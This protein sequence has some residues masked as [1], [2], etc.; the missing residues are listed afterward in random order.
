MATR[1]P[2]QA[3]AWCKKMVGTV[4]YGGYCL[5]FSRTA[6][7]IPGRYA[8]AKLAWA[9]ADK[10]HPTS[11]T[12][13][14]PV[15]AFLFMTHPKS[16]HG[17]VGIYAGNG[18]Y[19]TTN[20]STN[21]IHLA[22]VDTWRSWGYSVIGWSEDLNGVTVAGL[23]AAAKKSK[24]GDRWM[25]KGE[26]GSARVSSLQRQLN[27]TFPSYSNLK[28]DGNFGSA[29]EEVVKEFQRRSGLVVDGIVGPNTTAT[30]K[31]YG[32]DV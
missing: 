25:H 32:I 14:I 1:T 19:F 7:N 21:R 31:R 18:L 30:L 13:G 3:I 2:A 11:S 26:Y 4:G 23:S 22:K 27:K 8:S 6:Y 29:T 12:A 28:V 5:K 15:G 17:H 10:R 24:S 20:S 16:V 9:N